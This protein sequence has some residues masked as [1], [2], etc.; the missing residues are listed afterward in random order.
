MSK[1]QRKESESGP[2]S[3]WE[4]TRRAAAESLEG[5]EKLGKPVSVG[6]FLPIQQEGEFCDVSVSEFWKGLTVPSV[7]SASV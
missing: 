7:N 1:A 2:W 3:S 4:W 5:Q 6:R